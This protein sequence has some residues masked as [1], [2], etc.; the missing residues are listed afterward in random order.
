MAEKKHLFWFASII[1]KLSLVLGYI[2][3]CFVLL[4]MFIIIF[5]VVMRHIFNR[6]TI[7]ADEISCYLL[8]GIAFLGSAYTLITGGHIRVEL[9]ERL[10]SKIRQRFE[11][12][13]DIISLAFLLVLTYQAYKLVID[14]YVSVKISSTLLRTPLFLPQ[15]LIAIGL[16]CLCLQ[17]LIQIIQYKR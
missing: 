4:M 11:F 8:V 1:E 16:T 2:S 17:L 12:T 3:G 14:S 5:D 7:W 6:P 10:A 13:T 15:L 9:I